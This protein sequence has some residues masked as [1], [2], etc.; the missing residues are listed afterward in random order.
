MI[1]LNKIVLDMII[2]L[3]FNDLH[4]SH[5]RDRVT[6]TTSF[7]VFFC[8]LCFCVKLVILKLLSVYNNASKF[9]VAAHTK[10]KPKAD[11]CFYAA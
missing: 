9:L 5:C 2:Y 1:N 10:R 6:I 8:I 11:R 3:L 7:L 4:D